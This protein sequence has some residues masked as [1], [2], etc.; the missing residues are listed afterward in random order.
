MGQHSN[1]LLRQCGN[2]MLLQGCSVGDWLV[3]RFPLSDTKIALGGFLSW[4]SASIP[5]GFGISAG[6]SCPQFGEGFYPG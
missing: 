6:K 5:Y 2:G 4:F 3:V 1:G